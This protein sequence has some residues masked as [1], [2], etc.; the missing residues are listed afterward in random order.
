M[1]LVALS[2]E[3]SDGDSNRQ[4]MI[5]YALWQFTATEPKTSC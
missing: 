4:F 5:T 3:N 2:I 1:C